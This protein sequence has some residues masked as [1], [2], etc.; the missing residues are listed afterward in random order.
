MK[1]TIIPS[2]AEFRAKLAPLTLA[3]LEALAK[4]CGVPFTTLVKIRNGQTG[5]PRLDTVRMVWPLV[6]KP[7]KAA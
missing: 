6:A 3:Q 2:A 1:T 4:R 7:A 5:N